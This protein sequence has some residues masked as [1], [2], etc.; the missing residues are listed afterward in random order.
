MKTYTPILRN[1][2]APL[3]SEAARR[4]T[5]GDVGGRFSLILAPDNPRAGAVAF[6]RIAF[7]N[8]NRAGEESISL[9]YDATEALYEALGTLLRERADDEAPF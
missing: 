4:L 3:M 6:I 1:D 5:I 2:F 9:D 7:Q 8:E